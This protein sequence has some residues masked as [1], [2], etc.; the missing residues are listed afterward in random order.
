[1]TTAGKSIQRGTPPPRLS[2]NSA[3]CAAALALCGCKLPPIELATPE[4][5]KVELNMRLDVYQYRGD[6]PAKS[7]AEM[8][9]L[10]EAAERQRNRM[11]EIQTIKNSRYV[12]EDHRGLLALRAPPAGEYGDYVKKTVE[13]ENEDRGLLMR[14]EAKES[15]RALHEVQTE[16]WK[17]RLANS[18]KGEW[19]EVPGDKPNTFKWTQAEGPQEQQKKDDGNKAAAAPAQSDAA[20]TSKPTEKKP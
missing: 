13:A 20:A 6:E 16:Q 10:G 4:P 19:I 14:N 5:I 15:N 18:F 2:R 11:A 7:K 3:V 9:T 1:M 12:G 17:L 8:K